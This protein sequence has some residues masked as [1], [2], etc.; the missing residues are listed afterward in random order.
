VLKAHG[1][2]EAVR[3]CMFY[4]THAEADV[5]AEALEKTARR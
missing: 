3:H 5:V 1:V 2:N 4:N